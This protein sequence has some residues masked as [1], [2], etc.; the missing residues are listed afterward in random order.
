MTI[1]EVVIV[2]ISKVYKTFFRLEAKTY[3]QSC[4]ILDVI[5]LFKVLVRS[6]TLVLLLSVANATVF[7]C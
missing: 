3:F 2:M 4:Y 6:H 1:Y 5:L 7:S